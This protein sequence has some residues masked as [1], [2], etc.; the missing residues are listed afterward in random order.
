[1]QFAHEQSIPG[2]LEINS[3]LIQE[4]KTYRSLIDEGSAKSIRDNCFQFADSLIAVSEQVAE[5]VGENEAARNKITTIPNG[6]DCEHFYAAPKER[7]DEDCGRTV[8]GFV[9]T[10]KPWHGVSILLDAFAAAHSKNPKLSLKIVG[11]GPEEQKLKNQLTEYCEAVQRSVTWLGAIPNS[12]IPAVVAAFD[13]A[14]APYPAMSG[15]YFSPLKILEYMAAGRPVVAS[16]IGQIPDL[17]QHD[18]TGRLV[19]PGNI[20]QLAT[21]L[22]NLSTDSKTRL[23][24]GHAARKS[25]EAHHSWQS[26]VGRILQTVPPSKLHCEIC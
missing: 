22:L 13:I 12:K 9:G 8:I 3:P 21:E 23:R 20:Q 2:I 25:V 10:L 6:V 1:M 17:I 19:A 5:I 4:Q 14:V 16:R 24:L 15:F 18:E 11:A 7:R 26:V